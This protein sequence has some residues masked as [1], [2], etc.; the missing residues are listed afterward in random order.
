M[1]TIN[2][3]KARDIAHDVRRAA[4]TA[5]FAPLD[6]QATIPALAAQAEAQRQQVRDKYAALQGDIDAASDVAALKSVIDPLLP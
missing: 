2:L 3:G 1:I 5:E 6:V 4:R